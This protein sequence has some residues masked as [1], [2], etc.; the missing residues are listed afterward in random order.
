M[1]LVNLIL[2][3]A[4]TVV[5]TAQLGLGVYQIYKEKVA[6]NAQNFGNKLNAKNEKNQ[7]SKEDLQKALLEIDPVYLKMILDKAAISD[8]DLV[9]EKYANLLS[10]SIAGKAS[11]LD[12]FL[13][14]LNQLSP[15]EVHLLDLYYKTGER[16][17]PLVIP[18]VYIG[19]ETTISRGSVRYKDKYNY[20]TGYE[21]RLSVDPA[22]LIVFNERLVSLGLLESKRNT[23]ELE[24]QIDI[25]SKGWKN[26]NEPND[27]YELYQD[28][29]SE[30]GDVMNN[31]YLVST[32]LCDR[33][34]EA[35]N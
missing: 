5:G 25:G 6:A 21:K 9:Q 13:T 8:N 1:E 19:T 7:I 4:Q 15:K 29:L 34:L 26:L 2:S 3:G 35:C 14:V 11:Q 12:M 17:F 10:N 20:L 23:P 32:P 30:P 22:S 24:F 16:E 27:L 18:F 33:L 31:S 28:L